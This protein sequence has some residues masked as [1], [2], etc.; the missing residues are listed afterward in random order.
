MAGRQVRPG[1]A[2][3]LST[4]AAAVL[5]VLFALVAALVW[6]LQHR[7]APSPAAVDES[8]QAKAWSVI[9][10]VDAT[11]E[12]PQGYVGGRRFMNDE[13]GGTTA[14]PRRDGRGAV[15][16]YREYDVNPR[17]QGVDRG[18]QRLVMG[19]DGSAYVTPDHYVTW[20]RLR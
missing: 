9:E 7:G 2:G 12:P 4:R 10:V 1:Q 11:G 3:R 14:L 18:P 19:N 8:L 6:W 5:L 16:L 17:R 13:R 20:E 15:I